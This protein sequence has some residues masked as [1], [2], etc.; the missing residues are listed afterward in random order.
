MYTFLSDRNAPMFVM[1]KLQYGGHW[2]KRVKGQ[3]SLCD[4]DSF[5]ST[6]FNANVIYT[7]VQSKLSLDHMTVTDISKHPKCARLTVIHL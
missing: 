6:K 3:K 2:S 5:K 4:G 1:S 7:I